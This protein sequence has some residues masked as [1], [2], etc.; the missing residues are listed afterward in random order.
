M[1][2]RPG[3]KS[4]TPAPG[5]FR[6]PRGAAGGFLAGLLSPVCAPLCRGDPQGGSQGD[7]LRREFTGNPAAALGGG[8]H[9]LC[10]ALVRRVRTFFQ[11]F[12]RLDCDRFAGEASGVHPVVHPAFVRP[13]AEPVPLLGGRATAQSPGSDRRIRYHL[14]YA[15]QTRLPD[16]RL[17]HS[18]PRDGPP[19]PCV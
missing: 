5:L 3:W 10:S 11:E 2:Y 17:P 1:G 14:R 13:S 8:K 9:R 4:T 12:L 16:G 19:A 18:N 6:R 15:R 7:D